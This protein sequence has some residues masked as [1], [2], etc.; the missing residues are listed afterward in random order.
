MPERKVGGIIKLEMEELLDNFL[1]NP[2][3]K[4]IY[5]V[6][7]DMLE[8]KTPEEFLPQ[9]HQEILVQENPALCVTL[10]PILEMIVKL[11][12]K[13][14]DIILLTY[15]AQMKQVISSLDPTE[16]PLIDLKYYLVS[17]DS[18]T[19]LISSKFTPERAKEQGNSLPIIMEMDYDSLVYGPNAGLPEVEFE[20]KGTLRFQQRWDYS[21][22]FTVT[23]PHCGDKIPQKVLEEENIA[24]TL[25][26]HHFLEGENLL[27]R[28]TE[29]FSLQEVKTC[30]SCGENSAPMDYLVNYVL[31]V[32]ES[33]PI[34]LGK[35]LQLKEKLLTGV[36]DSFAFQYLVY[37]ASLIW[38]LEGEDSLRPFPFL[39]EGATLYFSPEKEEICS[40]ITHYAITSLNKQI[41]ADPTL[42]GEI[43]FLA[44][45][46]K[47]RTREEESVL[48][49]LALLRRAED[50]YSVVFGEKSERVQWMRVKHS[51]FQSTLAEGDIKQLIDDLNGIAENTNFPQEEVAELE[52][53]VATW[54]MLSQEKDQAIAYGDRY[55]SR[56]SQTF[57]EHSEKVADAHGTIGIFY[58]EAENES[59]ALQHLQT[60][61]TLN[62]QALGEI[63][64]LPS[65]LKNQG[66]QGVEPFDEKKMS[67]ESWRRVWNVEEALTSFASYYEE[68]GRIFTTAQFQEK[69]L[70][71]YDWTHQ[72][73]DFVKA[74]RLKKLAQTYL[75][76]NEIECAKDPLKRA[77]KIYRSHQ[78]DPLENQENVDKMLQQV[79]QM[80]A[81]CQGKIVELQE[82]L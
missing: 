51:Y 74:D 56:L 3:N 32:G 69:W 50:Y 17:L 62:L 41:S 59:K 54:Y 82:F 68:K 63:Y 4:D 26:R 58:L 23:C 60:A 6:L 40:V 71:L 65:L 19:T 35:I 14:R 43:C 29:I 39:M 36:E 52:L 76:G 24:W 18:M 11:R 44:G 37:I 2:K 5:V 77:L 72:E 53:A 64:D 79:I 12:R 16:I 66:D 38:K 28:A 46:A 1:Q 31:P 49:G 30:P 80:L 48:D 27:D 9:L 15:L 75:N 45:E 7:L 33:A 70:E 42:A 55:L 10:F 34:T 8:S 13:S 57:G 67:Q 21:V 73:D 81:S 20:P 61:L 78:D 22:P 47:C 25:W